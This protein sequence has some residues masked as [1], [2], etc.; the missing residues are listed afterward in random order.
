LGGGRNRKVPRKLGHATRG[1]KTQPLLSLKYR[2]REG[3]KKGKGNFRKSR[4]SEKGRR[5]IPLKEEMKKA[6]S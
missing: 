5:E 6:R 1:K 2:V 3:E 4:G